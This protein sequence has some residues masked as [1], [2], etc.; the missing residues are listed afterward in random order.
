MFFS[1]FKRKK[2]I[3]LTLLVLGVVASCCIY[4]KFKPQASPVPH[5]ETTV[6]LGLV[7]QQN[8]PLSIS[9][10]GNLLAPESIMLSTQQSGMITKIYFKNGQRVKQGDLLVQLDDAAQRAAYNK[11]KA[12]LY[13]TQ[14]QYN[15]YMQLKKVDPSILSQVQLDQVYAAYQEA[16]A[17]LE[18]D[19]ENLNQMQLRAP[20]SGILG[21]TNVS[22]GSFLNVGA[23]IVA[24]INP[25]DLEVAYPVPETSFDLVKLGQKVSLQ[26]DAYPGKTFTGTVVFKGSLVD[27]TS[28]AF[29][30]RARVDDPKGLTPG[31]LVRLTQ[32]LLAE[33][34]VIAVPTSAL[35]AE[36]S[37]FAVYQVEAGKVI[38]TYV[39]TG[40]QFGNYTEISS[41][42]NVG[43]AIITE[44]N[45][46][47]Q[48]GMQVTVERS[49]S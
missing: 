30:V 24:L 25:D 15:R 34:Q 38:E 21:A 16:K 5:V 33:R 18:G 49:D 11:D 9:S 1:R 46:K 35:V 47:V 45:Q 17:T 41:G 36:M 42:L 40:A 43:D 10:L 22:V 32:I 37:G 14:T 26:T 31:M 6:K 20:F 39:K 13:E 27:P 4:F 7:Q 3:L 23:Q 29:N 28:R 44:G 12:A 19:T 8:V 2:I 48:T